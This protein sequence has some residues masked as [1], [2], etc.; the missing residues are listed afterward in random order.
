M[1][2]D[3]T[4]NPQADVLKQVKSADVEKPH[5]QQLAEPESKSSGISENVEI[6]SRAMEMKNA[7]DAIEALSDVN[8]DK[9]AEIKSRIEQGAYEVNSGR[10]A[11][12]IIQDS[13]LNLFA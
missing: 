7:R 6:S 4:I 3:E 10:I 1:K 9:V 2:I 13:L 5:E 12:K 11:E 8:A